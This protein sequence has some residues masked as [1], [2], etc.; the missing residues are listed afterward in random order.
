MNKIVIYLAIAT[1]LIISKSFAQETFE[2]RAKEISNNI[3]N[4]VK[5]EKK[6]LK[7][8]IEAVDT[9]IENKEITPD[10]ALAKKQELAN[11]HATNIETKVAVEQQKLNDLI[12]EKV[13]GKIKEIETKK[14][15]GFAIVF[16]E[17]DESNKESY[18][19]KNDSIERVRRTT[20][21]L[22]FA[23]G[24]NNVLTNGAIAKS[25]FRYLGSHF[26]EFG[27]TFNTRLSKTNSL[28]HLKYGLT[29]VW[30]NLR[31]TDNQEFIISG[32]Q[33]NLQTSPIKLE[34][35]RFRNV[36]LT[37]PVHLEFDFSKKYIHDGKE[38][39]DSHEAFRFGLGGYAGINLNSKQFAEISFNK[40]A[41]ESET[42]GDFNTS[43][44]I[45]GTSAYVGYKATSLYLKYDLNTVFRNN[46]V[47]QNNIS[48]GIRFDFN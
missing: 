31:L 33:T 29:G 42:E 21:Q 45:Y 48:V 1:S 43:N 37:C 28:L 38:Y 39:F 13:D 20:S 23:M 7:I 47:K 16:N 46:V 19:N 12:K 22:V 27:L 9:Q 44:F 5:S 17:S 32:N 41:T 8:E 36:Y 26:Y 35:S 24:L 25:D 40:Y 4:I 10:Q 15:R 18:R 30:N 3:E 2:N 34:D 14:R 6:A 11:F